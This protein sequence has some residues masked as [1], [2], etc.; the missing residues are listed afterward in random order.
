MPLISPKAPLLSQR[1]QLNMYSGWHYK[2]NFDISEM[3]L[4]CHRKNIVTDLQWIDSKSE[5]R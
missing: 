1:A 3:L 2:K 4:R 5:A